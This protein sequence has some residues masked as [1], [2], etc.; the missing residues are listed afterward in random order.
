[1]ELFLKGLII[2]GVTLMLITLVWQV[3]EL[4]AFKELRPDNFHT[5]IAVA[6]ALSITINFM[7]MEVTKKFL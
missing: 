2:F 4:I 1:M 5:F 6:L 3:Y 7:F